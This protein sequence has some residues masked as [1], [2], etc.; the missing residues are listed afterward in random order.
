LKKTCTFKAAR[1]PSG[2]YISYTE[3]LFLF[4]LTHLP[5][6]NLLIEYFIQMYE[7]CS[8]ALHL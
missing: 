3:L 5:F 1:D 4:L 2:Q 6:H 8:T 7:Y